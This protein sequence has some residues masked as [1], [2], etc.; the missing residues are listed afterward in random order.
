MDYF[1]LCGVVY[2]KRTMRRAFYHYTATGVPEFSPRKKVRIPGSRV[3]R[4]LLGVPDEYCIKFKEK[5]GG[6]GIYL[7]RRRITRS[8]R[9]SPKVGQTY[10]HYSKTSQKWIVRVWDGNKRLSRGSYP[11]LL[12]A[13]CAIKSGHFAYYPDMRRPK[14]NNDKHWWRLY[15]EM[16][17]SYKGDQEKCK[18]CYVRADWYCCCLRRG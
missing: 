14:V 10:V 8:E 17:G 12:D 7:T 5:F 1:L 6:L 3:M 13:W 2:D 11:T 16:A 18:L 15:D 4:E 9:T